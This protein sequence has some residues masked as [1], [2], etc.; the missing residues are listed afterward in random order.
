MA[1]RAINLLFMLWFLLFVC[2]AESILRL[3]SEGVPACTLWGS[4]RKGVTCDGAAN[5]FNLTPQSFF[6]LN[7]NIDCDDLFVGQWVCVAGNATT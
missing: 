4:V 7:P 3:G 5:D 6:A 1:S 2:V